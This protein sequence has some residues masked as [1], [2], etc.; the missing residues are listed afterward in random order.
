MKH[1]SVVQKISML[2]YDLSRKEGKSR[3]H[4]TLPHC[5]IEEEGSYSGSQ[6]APQGMVLI[7][8]MEEEMLIL[9]GLEL[10]V[11]L[12]KQLKWKKQLKKYNFNQ[13]G[14]SLIIVKSSGSGV[15]QTRLHCFLS[16][17]TLGKLLSLSWP[18]FPDTNPFH[19]VA[20]KF[21]WRNTC[22]AFITVPGTWQMPSTH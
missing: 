3:R 10:L 1:H 20:F 2:K 16:C 21:G 14:S 4:V 11:D 22:K 7:F 15:R 12:F 6:R 13:G 5:W 17:V 18:Q 19:R 8:S 9:F